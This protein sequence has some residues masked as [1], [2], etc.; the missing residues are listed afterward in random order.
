VTIAAQQAIARFDSHGQ[1][2]QRWQFTNGG[3]ILTPVGIAPVGADRFIA[4]YLNNGL[5][6]VFSTGQ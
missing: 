2:L 5:A 4:L 3:G 6:A 1:E